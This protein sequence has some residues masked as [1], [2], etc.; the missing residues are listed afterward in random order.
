MKH[1]SKINFILI[2]LII[3]SIS[4]LQ[5]NPA[6]EAVIID[7][8]KLL[9]NYEGV[10]KPMSEFQEKNK[11]WQAN[12]DTLESRLKKAIMD[13]EERIS[14]MSGKERR[15]TEQEL[16]VQRRKFMEYQQA[17][18]KKAVE[19]DQRL[20]QEVKKDIDRYVKQYAK[21]HDIKLIL[22]ATGNGT[23][24]YMDKEVMDIT[25]ELTEYINAKYRG[26]K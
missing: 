10:K 15:K 1:M 20:M 23:I 26:E 13:Y 25:D 4:Y 2:I 8:Q 12:V 9:T 24:V 3:S 14:Q 11:K 16:T 5:F 21:Q 7:S 18:Q 6:K 17:I 22:G 19:E